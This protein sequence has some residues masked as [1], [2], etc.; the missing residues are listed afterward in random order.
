V[1][2]AGRRSLAHSD[3][4]SLRD[5]T[6]HALD[7]NLAP[8][9]IVYVAL[10]LRLLERR[11]GKPSDGTVEEAFSRIDDDEGWPAKLRAWGQ[12]RLADPQLL[13]AAR[14]RTEQSEAT[15]YTAM[16]AFVANDT[17]AAE[18]LASFAKSDAIELV[19]VSIARD[20]AA[21]QHPLNLKVPTDVEVP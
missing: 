16:A 4:R 7:A 3:L 1:L 19:E 6:R 10:W 13:A 5:A 9:D 17:R 11:L 2:D 18:R 15:F 14:G 8:S 12:G 21:E 20:I